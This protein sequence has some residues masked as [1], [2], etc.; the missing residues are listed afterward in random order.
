MGTFGGFL[1]VYT[2]MIMLS[3]FNT[4]SR[5]NQLDRCLAQEMY[6]VME[7]YYLPYM[8][9]EVIVPY[10]SAAVK[11]EFVRNIQYRIGDKDAV[12]IVIDS[13]DME[14]GIMSVRVEEEF[15]VPGGR[16]KTI[17][18]KKTIISDE[19]VEND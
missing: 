16:S 1:I 8:Y 13:C 4:Y 5:K 3:S 14:K 11:T 19:K 18:C 6:S 2:V 15:L 12:K 7:R 17:T 10:D 9:G